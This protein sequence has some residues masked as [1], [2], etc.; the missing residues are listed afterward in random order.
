LRL[1]KEILIWSEVWPLAIALTIFI[2]FKQKR[3]NLTLIF[4]LLLTT[5]VLHFTACFISRFTYLFPKEL[6]NNNIL[7]NIL[8]ICKPLLAG[9]YLMRLEQLKKYR[10]LK[11]LYLFFIVFTIINFSFFESI[12]SFSPH[13]VV[14]ESIL[15]LIFTL[16]FFL[17][18]MID[19]D[20][21]MPVNHPAY[22]FCAAISL[23]ESINFFIY[24]FLFPVFNENLEF[25]ILMIN[26][27]ALAYILYGL[28]IATGLFINRNGL[29]FPIKGYS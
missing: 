22:F 21:P 24:L 11:F 29:R 17:D 2:I 1:L 12:F 13:M 19:D 14:A 15:L 3:E 26:I 25:A 27:S 7:Y 10:Y 18:A 6:K 23:F 5:L 16:T 28:L 20:I 8:A 9:A 4:W